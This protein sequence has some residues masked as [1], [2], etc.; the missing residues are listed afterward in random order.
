M[1]GSM[2]QQH[3]AEPAAFERA[4][5]MRVLDSYFHTV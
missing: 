3:C 2:S 5:Y 4:N 1:I